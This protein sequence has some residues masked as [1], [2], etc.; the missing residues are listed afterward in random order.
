[1]L[2]IHWTPLSLNTLMQKGGV[3]LMLSTDQNN[4]NFSFGCA[5]DLHTATDTFAALDDLVPPFR[6]KKVQF[7]PRQST[8]F[9]KQP[10]VLGVLVEPVGGKLIRAHVVRNGVKEPYNVFIHLLIDYKE[11][12]H[13]VGR[14]LK[15]YV[16]SVS[17]ATEKPQFLFQYPLLLKENL[18]ELYLG[19]YATIK[20]FPYYS[21]S[22]DERY[23]LSRYP[24]VE[25]F[26]KASYAI[27]DRMN[28]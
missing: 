14:L 18:A 4:G 2:S 26:R 13:R 23:N 5:I 25:D 16:E 9:K 15:S 10:H 6:A 24:Q 7:L 8:D 3:T 1:M 11:H 22:D 19:Q 27:I 17:D 21:E 20:G 28:R 12:L